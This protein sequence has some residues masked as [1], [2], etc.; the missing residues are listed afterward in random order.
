LRSL[1]NRKYIFFATLTLEHA[2]LKAL[3]ERKKEEMRKDV[4]VY[5]KAPV[6]RKRIRI[7]ATS[8]FTVSWGV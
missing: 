1:N 2:K 5:V 8:N 7:G 3:D 4:N 6:T